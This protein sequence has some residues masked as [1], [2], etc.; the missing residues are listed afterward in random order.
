M[1]R[2]CNINM[3]HD[4]YKV[5]VVD[6]IYHDNPNLNDSTLDENLSFDQHCGYVRSKIAQSTI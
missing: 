2:F 3:P 6:R 1:R 5:H 4:P